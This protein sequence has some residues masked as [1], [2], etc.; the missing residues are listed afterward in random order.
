MEKME[1]YINPEY[2]GKHNYTIYKKV[3]A[4]SELDINAEL[5][6]PFYNNVTVIFNI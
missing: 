2:I 4:S 6:L 5:L 1:F 3:N